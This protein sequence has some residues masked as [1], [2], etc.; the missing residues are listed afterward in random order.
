[1]SVLKSPPP[2]VYRGMRRNSAKCA[3][4]RG[5]ITASAKG[6]NIEDLESGAG[7]FR[8]LTRFQGL[9]PCFGPLGGLWDLG[10]T[11]PT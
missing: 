7:L 10:L 3:V 4:E 9:I 1:M 6:S 5:F 11:T 8:M 2:A